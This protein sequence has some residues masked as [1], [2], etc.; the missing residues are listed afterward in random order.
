[1]SFIFLKRL[2]HGN[3]CPL[4]FI[5]FIFCLSFGVLVHNERAFER[6]V[7][8]LEAEQ[9]VTAK[10]LHIDPKFNGKFKNVADA[11]KF[12]PKT[13]GPKNRT[14]FSHSITIE[15]HDGARSWLRKKGVQP[16]L[17]HGPETWQIP[18]DLVDEFN[19][20]FV[21]SVTASPR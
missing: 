15:L 3:G 10:G 17:G 9:S 7:S 19:D 20:L 8:K 1:M 12:D 11:G 13:L 4:S 18:A 5:F 21:K 2:H 16:P 14:Q 6:F